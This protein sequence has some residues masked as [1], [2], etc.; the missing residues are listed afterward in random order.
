M[1]FQIKELQKN[2]LESGFFDTMKNLKSRNLNA[3]ISKAKKILQEIQKNPNHKIFV[4]ISENDE[5]IGSVTLILEQK[6]IQNFSLWGHLENVVTRK[7]YEGQGIGR[8]LIK[9][10]TTMAKEIGCAKIVLSCNDD[11]IG[12]YKKCGYK[13]Q[14]NSMKI[15][16][17]RLDTR[18][19]CKLKNGSWKLSV[20]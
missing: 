19:D 14:S 20:K 7:G 18:K 3:N 2:H 1:K 11:K 9:S 12:F 4:A 17:D 5:V 10:V 16:L 8:T 15:D 13:K 6:F